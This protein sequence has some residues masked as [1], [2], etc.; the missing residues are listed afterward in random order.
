M[1][2]MNGLD[3]ARTLRER[4]CRFP[5]VFLTVH[6]GADSVRAALSSGGS[7]YVM[8]S[9]IRTDLIPAIEAA[10]SGKV[11]VSSFAL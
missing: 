4:G 8:K 1:G 3:V 6:T 5:I 7:G 2:S 9:H 11:F 10:V